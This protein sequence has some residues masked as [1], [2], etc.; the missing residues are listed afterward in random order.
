MQSRRRRRDRWKRREGRRRQRGESTYHTRAETR[1]LSAALHERETEGK[2]AS[3]T[4]AVEEGRDEEHRETVGGGREEG[5][6]REG[7]REDGGRDLTKNERKKQQNRVVAD[8]RGSFPGSL[9]SFFLPL[10]IGYILTVK[11]LNRE[12]WQPV[13]SHES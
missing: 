4:P 13:S 10:S 8:R 12:K 7:V 6:G 11:G 3:Q 9:S 1:E 2:T 5:G